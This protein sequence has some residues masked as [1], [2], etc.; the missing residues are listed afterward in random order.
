MATGS[1]WSFLCNPREEPGKTTFGWASKGF[2]RAQALHASL[3]S[4]GMC[5]ILWWSLTSTPQ[6]PL[7]D[8]SH[9]GRG[10][11]CCAV[12]CSGSATGA[13]FHLSWWWKWVSSPWKTQSASTLLWRKP[14]PRRSHLQQLWGCCPLLLLGENSSILGE[15]WIL[16][17]CSQ[18]YCLNQC[19]NMQH[20]ELETALSTRPIPFM[21]S[22][23]LGLLCQQQKY[24]NEKLSESWKM[25]SQ[26]W[27]PVGR[28][29]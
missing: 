5:R 16:S 26:L 20:M 8:T 22:K 14:K 21:N 29:F 2:G 24:L 17:T 10:E 25:R 4:L 6:T 12:K 23:A 18:V 1:E 28:I 15:N 13:C 7:W 19:L 27:S 9:S 11:G 3:S